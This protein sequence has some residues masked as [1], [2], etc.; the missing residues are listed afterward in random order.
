VE[1]KVRCKFGKTD[2]YPSWRGEKNI[3]SWGLGFK[4]CNITPRR[5]QLTYKGH[6]GREITDL[7][8]QAENKAKSPGE[9]GVGEHLQRIVH[10]NVKVFTSN[11]SDEKGEGGGVGVGAQKKS[12]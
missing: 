7:F 9:S 5:D 1:R 6:L 10:E 8:K 11:Q 3:G 2:Q 12:W 4:T